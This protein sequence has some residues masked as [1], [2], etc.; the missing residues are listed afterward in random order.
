MLFV[1][2]L[3]ITFILCKIFI[4][5]KILIIEILKKAL[6][7][8]R[9]QIFYETRICINL[10]LIGLSFF[11]LVALHVPRRR[12]LSMD[13]T[14]EPF[15]T[16]LLEIVRFN[17]CFHWSFVKLCPI[18]AEWM[19]WYLAFFEKI[20]KNFIIH[21]MRVVVLPMS[22]NDSNRHKHWA[23]PALLSLLLKLIMC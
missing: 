11:D 14:C 7:F 5:N 12:N 19:F 1:I 21:T 17:H 23:M 8:M 13:P 3:I 4:R 6:V 18:L 16:R 20:A 22:N 9:R 2:H 10:I 15:P